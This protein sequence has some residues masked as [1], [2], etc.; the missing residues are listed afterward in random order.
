MAEG[1]YDKFHGFYQDFES[2]GK[3]LTEASVGYEE[4][5]KKLLTGRGNL[6]HRVDALVGQRLI[7]PKKRLT[8]QDGYAQAEMDEVFH[9]PLSLEE[10][11]DMV[12][13]QE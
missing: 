12:G 11:Q 10:R 4:A 1:L 6:Y 13:N 2:V 8:R 5:H 3:K 7:S 9:E